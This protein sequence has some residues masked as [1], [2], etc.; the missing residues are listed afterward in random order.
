MWYVYVVEHCAVIKNH[1]FKENLIDDATLI[2]LTK[3]NSNK[4]CIYHMTNFVTHVHMYA[5]VSLYMSVCV[6]ICV[7]GYIRDKMM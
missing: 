1:I 2:S 6:W 3:N 5:C 4:N 7:F